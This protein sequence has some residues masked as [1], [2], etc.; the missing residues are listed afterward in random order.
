MKF[1]TSNDRT[2]WET[3]YQTHS[4]SEVSWS[5]RRLACRSTSSGLA[6]P[7]VRNRIIDVGGGASTLVDGLLGVGYIDVTVLDL[8]PT[9]LA[10]TRQRLAERRRAC[11]GS[12]P[13]R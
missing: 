8:S 2:H 3:V 6:A 12:R 7:S 13:M 9:A 4:P 11:C 5:S 10:K 1:F